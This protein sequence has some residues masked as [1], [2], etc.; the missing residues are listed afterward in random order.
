MEEREEMCHRIVELE[1]ELQ[2]QK[3]KNLSSRESC[4]EKLMKVKIVKVTEQDHMMKA[5]HEGH[6]QK[7]NPQL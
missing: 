1:M 7:Q 6:C 4:T 2:L 3:M 5:P